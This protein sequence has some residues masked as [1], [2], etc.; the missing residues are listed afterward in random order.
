MSGHLA[1]K[2]Y[3]LVG[4]PPGHKLHNKGRR[5]NIHARQSNVIVGEDFPK[6][7]VD[8]MNLI[9]NQ[10][11][12]ILQLLHE[13]QNPADTHPPMANFTS[14][15]SM[16][17][18]TTCLST[19][20]HKS[21]DINNVPWI[22]DT[23]A[24]DH[25]ICNTVFFTTVTATVSYNVKLPNGQEVP[26]THIGTVKLST[27]I[28]LENVLCVPSFTFNLLSAPT[29]TRNVSCC[30]VFLSNACFLQ[31][32][33]SWTTIGLGEMKNGLYHLKH[34]E[35]S[36]D[37][38]MCTLS[39]SFNIH[40]LHSVC[41]TNTNHLFDLWHHRLG[42][43]SNSRLQLIRDPVVIQT[44]R[45]TIN[46]VP[47]SICPLARQHRLP[48][49]QSLH[50]S[51]FNFELIHCDL[52]GPCSVAAYDGSRYFLTIVDDLSRSTWV[53]LL[54][55]KSDT[56]K[57]I[58]S[59]CNLIHT[60]FGAK[61]KYLRSDNGA[62]F[63]MQ[64][65]F[66]K[67]GIIHQRTCVETPQQNGIVERKH[68]HILNVARALRFQASLPLEFWNDCVLTA[69]YIINRIPTPILHNRTPYEA[70]FHTDP[71]YHHLRVFG[72]L[73][74][75]T[76][77]G[78]GRKKF[79]SRARKC[80]FLGYPF[81]V[82]GYK[83]VDLETH[84]ILLSRD[85]I[86]H[87]QIF[88][89]KLPVPE[90]LPSHTLLP[91]TQP[92]PSDTRSS[93]TIEPL[94]NHIPD[95]PLSPTTSTNL[96]SDVNIS[97]DTQ[98][99]YIQPDSQPS[100]FVSSS[101][102]ISQTP[103]PPLHVRKSARMKQAPKYLQDFH[104]QLASFN[105]SNSI[106]DTTAEAPSGNAVH[107]SNY[108]S[109]NKFSLPFQV[110][111]ASISSHTEPQ[112]Y[113]QA[114]TDP[115]WRMAM[116]DELKAL[117]ANQTWIMTDLP[118]GKRPIACKYVYKIKYNSDGSI[119]RYKARLV[120]K[121]YT[122]EEGIDYHETFSPVAK[123]V[124]VRCL[125][126]I[127]AVKGWGLYQFDVNNAFL[128]GDLQEE[129]YMKRPPG[130]TQGQSHQVCRLLKSLYGLKQASRQWY[131]KF[132]TSLLQFGFYQSKADYSL[133]IKQDNQSFT[134]LLVY[135]DDIIVASDSPAVV[136]D[137]KVF[138]NHQFKIKDL[139]QLRYF[140]GLEI[141]RTSQGIQICQRKY[142][143]DI[144]ATF[145]VLGSRPSKLPMDQNLKLSKEEGTPLSD[146]TYYRQLVG[147]L[148]YLTIT[149][150]D[151]SYS[152]Q[153][154]S[155]F[156]DHPTDFHLAAAFKILKYIK[157][158]PGQGL[159]FSSEHNLDI[160]AYC[161]S[162]WAS[163][164]DTRRSVSGFCIFLGSSLISWKSKKQ[165][166]VSRSS[167]EA[168]Y[169]AMA[170]TSSEITWL[171][172]LLTDLRINHPHPAVLYCDNKAALHIASNPVFHERTK[173]IELDCHLIRD[174][175][176]A[177][178]LSTAYVSTKCQLA[179]VFT[180]ALPAY[181]LSFHMSK[182]GIVNYYAPS[183]GG[184]LKNKDEDAKLLKEKG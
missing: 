156:M 150:P 91:L 169:R 173:H 80:A 183:C 171:S 116:E 32:L 22:I 37:A 69:T 100:D 21:F 43:I 148:L 95:T 139:G 143:L 49:N 117:E 16:S 2:C 26:V 106:Q 147:K 5:P 14:L 90:P 167:A 13:K 152:V 136:K 68:Q 144:L 65:F 55:Y 162:D 107:L 36:P 24:T 137:I 75:A 88:P 61:I 166:V 44:T 58:E 93:S 4:Y 182:M 97:P 163:C 130:Y 40:S 159:F 126:A 15:P 105:S 12:K 176:Q 79:D 149:R 7:Q 138:L 151:I 132:S 27:L 45:S 125:L 108:L 111:S 66:H 142:A 180:K 131:S 184:M 145:G 50:K 19:Y 25:M 29:L 70:I 124:T 10:Y 48:F 174:K 3:K 52:W 59:F 172:F 74:F 121:G 8:K 113:A 81:G 17:G 86:F 6:N 20:S 31:D 62:E 23:G 170:I 101:P 115:H 102:H 42:H 18:I 76:T 33:M 11:Q 9:S 64:D 46:E 112:T 1:E 41:A 92:Q 135:V 127:A 123:L 89:F 118:A 57:F 179:D 129:I 85:V 177:G 160:T 67:N 109:Y 63:H 35:V 53:Y 38:L 34:V 30:F 84:E 78:Q 164:P 110:F 157:G 158:A 128:H 47:C 82:K 120:A 28:T 96:S 155:Q 104:C 122:Q 154:L 165:S 83:L 87:E 60:Q 72:C 146:S 56:R 77:I 119:E 153:T 175:I 73:C 161:D 181:L 168:E 114:V 140:L 103:T 99:I 98:D 71:T 133:F 94:Q 134:A 178:V 54:R 39:K 51:S 141:A